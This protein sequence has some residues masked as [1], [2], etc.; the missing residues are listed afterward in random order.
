MV[1]AFMYTAMPFLAAEAV[2]GFLSLLIKELR[3]PP[4]FGFGTAVDVAILVAGLAVLVYRSGRK[5]IGRS[6]QYAAHF[7]AKPKG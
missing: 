6:A 2:T 1:K 7:S 4:V 5:P 3:I